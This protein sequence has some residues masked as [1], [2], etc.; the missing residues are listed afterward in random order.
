MDMSSNPSNGKFTLL[1]PLVGNMKGIISQASGFA[2]H[3]RKLQNQQE[4]YR[5]HH[6][7]P[8]GPV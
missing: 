1:V 8:E 3:V 6:A 7:A 5:L 4:Q 2:H